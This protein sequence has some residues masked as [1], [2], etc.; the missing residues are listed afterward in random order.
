MNANA[1]EFINVIFHNKFNPRLKP[2]DIHTTVL[3]PEKIFE[4]HLKGFI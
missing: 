3:S 1:N 2:N 4:I